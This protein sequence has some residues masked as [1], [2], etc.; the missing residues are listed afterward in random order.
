MEKREAWLKSGKCGLSSHTMYLWFTDT[1]CTE[2]DIIHQTSHPHDWDDFGRCFGL[3]EYIPEWKDRLDELRQ[4]S[5]IWNKLIDNW[6]I[7]S[8]L[9][10]QK[11]YL[12]INQ[13]IDSITFQG[14]KGLEY[15]EIT[16]VTEEETDVTS[17]WWWQFW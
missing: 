7:L 10:E 15:F 14:S 17:R 12:E 13:L 4:I 11:Q 9:Y 16:D 2:C 6:T 1:K 5:P 8:N 3:L